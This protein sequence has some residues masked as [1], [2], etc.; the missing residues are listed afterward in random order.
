MKKLLSVIALVLALNFLAL[1]GLAGYLHNTG[2]LTRDKLL[3]IKDILFPPPPPPAP[4]TQPAAASTQP[5][6][7]LEELLAKYAGRPPTEQL[8]YIRRSFD[9]QM[10][11]LDR[12][13]RELLHLQSQVVAEK[14]KL[15]AD[16]AALEAEKKKLE[17]QRLEAQR[18]AADQGFQDS[19]AL[20]ETLPAKQVKTVFMGLEDAVVIQ[21]LQAMEDRTAA[22]IMKEFKSP[23][24]AERLKQIMEK[25]RQAQASTKE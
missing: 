2:Q 9:S 13:Q 12:A 20:Y 7:R 23:E 14:Q 5:T 8:E 11:Q 6:L 21:Y 19:L 17:V 24:E 1:V 22:K 4:A 3:A 18:L 10:A 25:L 16:R 15:A